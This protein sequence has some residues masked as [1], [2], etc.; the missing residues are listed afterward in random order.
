MLASACACVRKED[1]KGGYERI[2][3]CAKMTG[4]YKGDAPFTRLPFRTQHGDVL[5]LLQGDIKE[6][7]GGEGDAPLP[8]RE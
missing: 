8:F 3:R 6:M 4:T 7:Q 5:C 1:M 2:I